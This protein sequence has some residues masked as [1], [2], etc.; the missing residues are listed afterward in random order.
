MQRSCFCCFFFFQA[1]DGIRDL[2]VTG[3]QTCALPILVLATP[4]PSGQ[5]APAL[6]TVPRRPDSYGNQYFFA[7]A[8][9][10]VPGARL[11]LARSGP[12]GRVT[13]GG[14]V[15]RSGEHTSELQAQSNIVCRPLLG[16]KKNNRQL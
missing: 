15:G 11:A 7:M 1:E 14:G 8:G 5:V 4:L 12:W 16:K 6:P 13:G 3:V 2:T 10:R 9:R